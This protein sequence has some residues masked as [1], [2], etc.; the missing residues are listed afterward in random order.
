SIAYETDMECSVLERRLEFLIK[1]GLVEERNS[2]R[3]TLYAITERGVA[4]FKTLNFQ[5]Y[6]EKV[7]SNIRII[8]EATHIIP[9]I[10]EGQRKKTVENESY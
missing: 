6:L 7:V 2:G 1:N 9:T 10:S 3:K 5:R 4:V 8:D